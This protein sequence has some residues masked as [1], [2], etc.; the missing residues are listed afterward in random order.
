MTP[1][2]CLLLISFQAS[3]TAESI[4]HLEALLE[5]H[6]PSDK[7]M[8]TWAVLLKANLEDVKAWVLDHHSEEPPEP[9]QMPTP[10][11]STSPEPLALKAESPLLQQ[12]EVHVLNK[13]VALCCLTVDD[14]L[15]TCF[16]AM[17]ADMNTILL[18]AVLEATITKTEPGPDTFGK[19]P[20]DASEFCDMFAPYEEKMESIIS[21]LT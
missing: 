3:L 8:F 5:D 1:I 19:S 17:D 2:F 12:K 20:C 11:N 21:L 13:R 18:D 15:L 6:R 9:F 7:L 16:K 10:H 14:I 4:Q